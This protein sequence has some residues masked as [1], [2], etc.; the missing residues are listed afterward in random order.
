[1]KIVGIKILHEF[2]EKH[3]DI[4]SQIDAWVAEA[5]EAI[6]H[7]PFDIKRRYASASF[8]ADNQVVFNLK[9]NSYRLLVKVNYNNQI[10]LIK[11][12]GTHDEYL[13]W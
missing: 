10:I 11:K 13:K 4:R 6:W 3:A 12:V 9:G 1:M 7:N 8:L 2:K 5:D